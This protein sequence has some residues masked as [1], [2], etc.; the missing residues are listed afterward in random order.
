[1]RLIRAEFLKLTRSLA[2][3]VVLVL[4]VVLVL[5]GSVMTL[6]DGQPLDDGWH[7]LW[8]RSFV[9]YG[10]FPLPVGIAILAAL[11]WRPEHRGGNWNLLMSGTAGALR[12]IIAKTTVIAFLSACMQV[13]ALATVIALG[14]VAFSLPGLPPAQYG[15]A[16]FLIMLSCVPV[17]ALQSWLSM[18]MRSFAAPVAVSFVG[19]GLSTAVLLV[20]GTIP[21][22]FLSPYATL[23]RATQ[24]GTAT[25]A[26]SGSVTIALVAV[27]TAGAILLTATVTALQTAVLA[28]SDVR[29]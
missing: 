2:W 1:M 29:T 11:V 9:F 13:V 4:P 6:L 5:V 23:T 10:L 21:I 17:A 28:R 7:T 22:V 8:M 3:V 15:V 24:L 18:V 19:A 14:R 26:D 16:F 20:V 27:L 25:F 12:I